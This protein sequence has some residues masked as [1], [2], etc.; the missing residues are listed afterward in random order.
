MDIEAMQ[1]TA[2]QM[3]TP[4]RPTLLRSPSSSKMS[5]QASST[6]DTPSSR[7]AKKNVAPQAG[8]TRW[9][10]NM[11]ISCRVRVPESS[12]VISPNIA[13]VNIEPAFHQFLLGQS[14][15]QRYTTHILA[16]Y[17]DFFHPFSPKFPLPISVF[18]NAFS[19]L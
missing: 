11:I 16:I 7:S 8:T 5:I 4:Y 2:P 13:R 6:N 19:P 10:R 1:M 12:R 14:T 18:V 17:P 3:S 15:Y 9:V